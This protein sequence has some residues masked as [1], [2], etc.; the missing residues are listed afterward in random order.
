MYEDMSEVQVQWAIGMFW[1]CTLSNFSLILAKH[2]LVYFCFVNMFS[3]VIC[4]M[5]KDSS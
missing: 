2:L 3:S 1:S 5:F 4:E